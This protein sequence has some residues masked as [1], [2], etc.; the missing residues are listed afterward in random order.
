MSKVDPPA[1]ISD[2]VSYAQYK[3]KLR[4]WSAITN[5]AARK[6]ADT[7]IYHLDGHSSRIQEKIDAKFGATLTDNEDGMKLLTEFLDTIYGEDD[8]AK[9]W[10]R[11]KKFIGLRM[12][13]GRSVTE[14]IAEYDKDYAMAKECGCELSDTVLAFCLLEACKLSE[15]DEKLILCPSIRRINSIS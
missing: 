6:Q 11:F 4:R 1:F 14:F 12:E 15:T 7:V 3:V 13:P 9:S 5:I 10:T 8:M 2:T